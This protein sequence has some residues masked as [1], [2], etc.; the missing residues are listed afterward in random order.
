MSARKLLEFENGKESEGK[1]KYVTP[2][3]TSYGSVVTLTR[4]AS[5]SAGDFNAT[6][7]PSCT[8]A[9][10]DSECSGNV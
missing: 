4:G 10:N 5:G 9:G 7:T 6:P 3:L 1:R 8:P 2:R